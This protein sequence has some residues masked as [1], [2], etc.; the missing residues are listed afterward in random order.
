MHIPKVGLGRSGP[1]LRGRY[2]P[3][4]TPPKY[5]WPTPPNRSILLLSDK[6][7]DLKYISVSV[8]QGLIQNLI[9]G[10]GQ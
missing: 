3:W 1:L 10:G 9:K 6:L 8:L 4:P 2:G 5:Q 7:L